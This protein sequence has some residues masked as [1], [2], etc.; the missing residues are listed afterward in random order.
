MAAL[1][2][3]DRGYDIA[4]FEKEDAILTRASLANEGK[5]HLGFVYA[6]DR[7][8]RTAA[9]M[10]TDALQFRVI[11]ERWIKSNDFEKY[12][13]DPFEYIVPKTSALTE[14]II[15]M[16]FSRVINYL[17]THQNNLDIKYLGIEDEDLPTL[18]L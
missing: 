7:S 16:H 6:A 17:H 12:I 18:T 1:E 14:N 2:L 11:L 8:F 13:L 4:L 9:R 3:A 10:I 15:E 5:I